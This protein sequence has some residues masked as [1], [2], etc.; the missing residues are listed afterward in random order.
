MNEAER[1]Q[2]LV[3]RLV[4][5][6]AD[7]QGL[8][9][10]ERGARASRGLQ[11][12][13]ANADASAA[14]ALATAFPT[15]Q[16]LVGEHDFALLARDHWRA[17]PPQRGDLGAWGGDFA[18][19]LSGDPRLADWPYLADCARLDWT[20]F[21]CERA[22]DATLD[23]ASMA[24]LADTDPARLVLD[25]MPGVALVASAW[26]IAQVHAAHHGDDPGAFD[27]AGAAIAARRGQTVVVARAGWKARV[28][29]VDDAA[30]CFLQALLDGVDLARALELAGAGFDFGAWLAG[31]LEHG[32]LKGI[33]V[34]AD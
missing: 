10:R 29:V 27:A 30:A 31:A 6:S 18:Q 33:R 23:A 8:A 25:P 12:Y 15:V 9:L 20:L 5:E 34:R 22:A 7:V 17:A 14:R 26:P 13:R 24:R 16:Q 19:A 32:V 28:H 2:R 21:Q 4:A 3:E 11:A 1:Q